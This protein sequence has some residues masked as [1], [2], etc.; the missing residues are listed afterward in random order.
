MAPLLGP[1]ESIGVYRISNTI[2]VAAVAAIVMTA[3]AI[4]MLIFLLKIAVFFI[5]CSMCFVLSITV[6]SITVFSVAAG[7]LDKT[8]S[9]SLEVLS[10]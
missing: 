10:A 6:F 1:F 2:K 4:M 7:L 9:L 3:V 8:T 5:S